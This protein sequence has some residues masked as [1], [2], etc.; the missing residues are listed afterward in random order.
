[1]TNK[2]DKPKTLVSDKTDSNI[3]TLSQREETLIKHILTDNRP[4][5]NEIHYPKTETGARQNI[6]SYI[7]K[8]KQNNKR[9]EHTISYKT[10]EFG[11]VNNEQYKNIYKNELLTHQ[12]QHRRRTKGRRLL[13]TRDLDTNEVVIIE[14]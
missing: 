7:D 8:V 9:Y 1:M 13:I 5:S 2:K 3:K 11:N 6:Q 14:E 4:L 10:P 12:E